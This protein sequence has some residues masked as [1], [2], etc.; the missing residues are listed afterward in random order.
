MTIIRHAARGRFFT[1]PGLCIL[2]DSAGHF[3]I[4]FEVF[5]RVGQER[6]MF[7]QEAMYFHAGLEAK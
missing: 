1:A 6:P 3:A 7:L 2:R 4:V 5:R